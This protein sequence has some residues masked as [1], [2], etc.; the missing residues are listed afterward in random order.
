MKLRTFRIIVQ[1][2]AFLVILALFFLTVYPFAEKYAI[3]SFLRLDPL[4]ALVAVLAS[5]TVAFS[6][7]GALVILLLTIFLG[8]FFCGYICPLGTLIDFTNH[9]FGKKN[10]PA[11]QTSYRYIKYIVL[12]VV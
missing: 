6:L 7:V 12:A 5:H 4:V 3:D 10:K 8:R 2:A 1:T 9:L 11:N